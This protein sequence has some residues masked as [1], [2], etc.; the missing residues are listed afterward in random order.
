MTLESTSLQEEIDEITSQSALPVSFRWEAVLHMTGQVDLTPMKV[1]AYDI[2]RDYENNICDDL[3]IE[4][5][6]SL[7]DYQ[8]QI[9]PNKSNLSVTLTRTTLNE[10]TGS[11][12][13][14]FPPVSQLYRAIVL[15]AS[16]MAVEGNTLM[17]SSVESA[18][19]VATVTVKFQ[20]N[21][22]TGEQSRM[23]TVGGIMKNVTVGDGITALMTQIAKSLSVDQN[24]QITG[25]EVTP[26]NNAQTYKHIVIPHG[27]RA[28]DVPAYIEHH[29]GA[30]YSSGMGSYIQ[31]KVWWIYPLYDLT[32]YDSAK[33]GLTI[34]NVPKNRMPG[35][36]RTYRTT[37]N[38]VIILATGAIS[39]ADIS[40]MMQLNKGNGTRFAD[41][42]QVFDSFATV[43]DNKATALRVNNATEALGQSR[44]TGLN[45]IMMASRS[46]TTNPMLMMSQLARNL[47]SIVMATWENSLPSLV[48]PGMPVRYMYE[49]NDQ[50]FELKGCVVKSQTHMRPSSPGL[51]PSPHVSTTV[52]TCFVT[53]LLDWSESA[54]VTGS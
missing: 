23:Q 13:P 11:S 14:S 22:L 39:H 33:K 35:A 51:L 20:L 21:D 42:G 30:P 37:Y 31:D 41:A 49:V 44:P 46:I 40:E 29:Y 36:N 8:H 6:F 47:G 50:V 32:R 7:G 18:N 12:N 45:N 2:V 9:L 52:L 24:H 5:V 25:V 4:L 15:D 28:M 1:M 53:R 10:V 38:Q 3:L 26:A 48:T 27:T 54:V 16:S 17:S 34:V 19:L 43:K